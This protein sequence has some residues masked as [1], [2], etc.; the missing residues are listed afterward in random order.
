MVCT[1][2]VRLLTLCRREDPQISPEQVLTSSAAPSCTQP[3]IKHSGRDAL[4]LSFNEGHHSL[5]C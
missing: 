2:L 4:H 3:P 1:E 5:V